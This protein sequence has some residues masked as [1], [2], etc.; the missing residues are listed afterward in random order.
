MG[1][2]A[3]HE[4]RT[5]VAGVSNRCLSTG[6]GP[7]GG[8]E[9]TRT[10]NFSRMGRA[11]YQLSYPAMASSARLERATSGVGNQC[12]IHLSYEENWY[13]LQDLNLRCWFRRPVPDP[14]G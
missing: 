5:R 6:L 12:S 1:H 2:G 3:D 4:N 8:R 13:P 11:L 10:L 9:G 7:H 14:L